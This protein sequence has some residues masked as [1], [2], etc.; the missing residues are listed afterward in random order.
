MKLLSYLRY[1]SYITDHWNLR[2]ALFTIFYEIKGERKYGIDT[3]GIEEIW[4]YDISTEDL[5]EA[6]S[7]QP[8]SYYIL[9]KLFLHLPPEALRGSIIDFGC[10]KGRALVVAMAFGFKKLI[11]V[12]IIHELSRDAEQ[13]LLHNKVDKKDNEF[14]IL[15]NRA[16]SIPIPDD[17]SVFL[18]FNPFKQQVME[19]VLQNILDSYKK[20]PRTLYVF[21][22]NPVYK[23]IFF[24]N[25]FRELYHVQKLTY[26]EGSILVLDGPD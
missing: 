8:S 26:L 22:L 18:F 16:Q 20:N 5:S 25:K 7:Y 3:T 1:G 24:D 13:N 17:S 11:G 10:G 4:Q 6:E 19:L 14:S 2:L 23:K 15:N 9:E 21:Y 12:E